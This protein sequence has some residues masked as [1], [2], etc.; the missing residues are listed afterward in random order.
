MI[1]RGAPAWAKDWERS[2]VV[3]VIVAW[4]AARALGIHFL[5]WGTGYDVNL[6][7]QYGSQFGSGGAPYVEFHPE[8]PPGA[9]PIFLMPLLWGGSAN[10][11][12]AFAAEMACFDLA[13]AVLALRIAQLQNRGH[14]SRPLLV[15]FLYIVVT[16]A[17]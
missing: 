2:S 9:L 3:L 1:S 5:G 17:L 11:G 12:R 15:S 14:W 4:A 6:Y 7:A 13:A 16:A 10:Y 8:Y